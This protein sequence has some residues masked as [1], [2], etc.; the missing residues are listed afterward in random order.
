MTPSLTHE[1]VIGITVIRCI[2]IRNH[3][4]PYSKMPHSRRQARQ[5]KRTLDGELNSG[6]Y[7]TPNVNNNILES[8]INQDG[9]VVSSPQG[10][11]INGKT[12]ALMLHNK[13]LEAFISINILNEPG[14]IGIY[15][16]RYTAELS[17]VINKL[18]FDNELGDL[19]VF[20]NGSEKKLRE[21]FNATT[22]NPL[23]A[24]SDQIGRMPE[25]SKDEVTDWLY[26]ELN[27]ITKSHNFKLVLTKVKALSS[28]GTTIWQLLSPADIRVADANAASLERLFYQSE[29]RNSGNINASF[30]E[31]RQ[32][33]RSALFDNPTTRARS[34]RMPV[35][36]GVP[37]KGVYSD[38]ATHGLG[39]GQVVQRSTDPEETNKLYNLLAGEHNVP[40]SQINAIRRQNAPIGDLNRPYMLTDNEFKNLPGKWDEKDKNSLPQPHNPYSVKEKQPAAYSLYNIKRKII[41]QRLSHG[42]GIN[43]WQPYGLF[44]TYANL[45]GFPSAGAQSGGTTDVMLA[46]QM[47][48]G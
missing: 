11:N 37:V 16:D 41:E 36:N 30:S 5:D 39:F 8:I 17:K 42:V 10:V 9:K 27:A 24:S 43:R 35:L 48:S 7:L 21:V 46:L 28:F 18:T 13:I 6:Q 25:G 14:E 12:S 1:N 40:N 3:I 33:T 29:L 15:L 31:F 38:A 19:R 47:L 32:N 45:A 22:F 26:K 44:G 20:L 34:E 4:I 2:P 23:S